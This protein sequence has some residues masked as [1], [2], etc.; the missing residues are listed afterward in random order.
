[1]LELDMEDCEAL[2]KGVDRAAWTPFRKAAAQIEDVVANLKVRGNCPECGG[3]GQLHGDYGQ[4]WTCQ[5]CQRK[6]IP[7]FINRKTNVMPWHNKLNQGER[8]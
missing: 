1:M 6:G 5:T 3:N 8:Q 2:L 4:D 7:S